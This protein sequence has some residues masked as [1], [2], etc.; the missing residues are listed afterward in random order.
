MLHYDF[1]ELLIM[2]YKLVGS[3]IIR[4]LLY[5]SPETESMVMYEHQLYSYCFVH[6]SFKSY[7]RKRE[8]INQICKTICFCI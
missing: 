4:R 1:Q 2:N 8:V 3:L 7:R 6:L 5:S